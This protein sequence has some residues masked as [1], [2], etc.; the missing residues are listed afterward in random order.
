MRKTFA[1]ALLSLLLWQCQ[2]IRY[3]ERPDDLIARDTM[4]LLFT[5]AYLTNAS[6]SFNKTI[7]ERRNIDLENYL[8][9]KYGIDSLRFERSNAFYTSDIDLYRE[10]MDQVK[11]EVDKR[12]VEVDT[13][14]A[15][16]KRAEKARRDSI[17]KL[18]EQRR[19]SLGLPKDTVTSQDIDNLQQAL[20]TV[21]KGA[22][23]LIQQLKD[24]N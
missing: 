13:I 1:I 2:D 3:P 12:L 6:K 15:I 8:L 9:N 20:D 4:V 18:A 23:K 7:I 11:S 14:I 17:R 22:G 16:E 19:D 5:D 24:D 21:P 10:M